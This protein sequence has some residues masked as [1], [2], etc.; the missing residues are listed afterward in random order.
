MKTMDCGL[1]SLFDPNEE[2]HDIGN[3][4]N[5][6]VNRRKEKKSRKS[7]SKSDGGKNKRQRILSPEPQLGNIEYKL[8]LISPSKHRFEHLFTHWKVGPV[9]D[10][11]M[12][13]KIGPNQTFPRL[14][15]D[16]DDEPYGPLLF[17]A[18]VSVLFHATAIY[19]VFQ[20]TMHIASIQQT[21]VIRAIDPA[22]IF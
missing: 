11:N 17:Q 10:D 14:L 7:S 1:L 16:C 12:Q 18:E 6:S 20:T 9:V 22:S 8:K 15:G 13:I 3:A 19:V 2:T 4:N 21:A 5:N